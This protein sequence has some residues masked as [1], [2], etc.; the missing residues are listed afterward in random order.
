[1]VWCTFLAHGTV[2]PIFLRDTVNADGYFHV[3]KEQCLLFL[4][5]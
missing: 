3:L 5:D 4:Q 1:M 2:G